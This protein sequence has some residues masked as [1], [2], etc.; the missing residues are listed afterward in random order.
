MQIR[1]LAELIGFL[2]DKM[3]MTGVYQPVIVLRLLERGGTASKADL[4]QALSE[5]DEAV[6]EYYQRVLMRWP[7]LTL[8]KHGVVSYDKETKVFSLNF[9]LEDASLME[10][11]KSLCEEKIEQWMHKRAAKSDAPRLG[12]SSKRYLVL[13]AAEGK[14]ELCGIPSKVSP[15]DVDHI[16]P[17]SRADKSGYIVKDGT[18]VHVDDRQNL[19]ALC[20]RCNRA[21]RNHDDTDFRPPGSKLVRDRIPEL[22]RESGSIPKTKELR[23]ERLKTA[24]LEKLVVEPADLLAATNVEEIVDMIEVLLALSGT[25]GYSE[26]ETLQ[27]LQN[28]RD[29]RGGFGRG[30]FLIGGGALRGPQD[31]E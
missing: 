1:P 5:H 20:F 11:A 25:L 19:Q 27:T 16:V 24:L 2:R 9:A 23:G 17:R 7:Y 22:I 3:S 8:S 28:K 4:A 30:V 14:C 21:K 26:R 12:V 29:E 31:G 10:R 6:Q 13:K 15:I 18:R